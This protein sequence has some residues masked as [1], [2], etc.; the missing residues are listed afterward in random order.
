M[1]YNVSITVEA[2]MKIPVTALL[3]SCSAAII[4]VLIWLDNL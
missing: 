4:G 3:S 1:T 2:S